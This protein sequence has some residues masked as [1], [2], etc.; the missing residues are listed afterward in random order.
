[1]R[2]KAKLQFSGRA[3]SGR[4]SPTETEQEVQ[5]YGSETAE[6]QSEKCFETSEAVEGTAVEEDGNWEVQRCLLPSGVYGRRP[7]PVKKPVRKSVVLEKP[8]DIEPS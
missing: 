1:M 7:K 6:T 4:G 5:G 8:F 2:T 3:D